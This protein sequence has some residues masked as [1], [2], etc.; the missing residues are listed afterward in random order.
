MLKTMSIL[1]LLATT[2]A[3]AD[4]PTIRLE[5]TRDYSFQVEMATQMV[6]ELTTYEYSGEPLPTV[7]VVTPAEMILL[8]YDTETLIEYEQK[9]EEPPVPNAFYTRDDNTITSI[10]PEPAMHTLVH[11]MVHYFQAL[12]GK[13]D[14][15]AQWPHCLEAEAYDVQA[16]WHDIMQLDMEDRP[17]SGFVMTLYAVCNDADFSWTFN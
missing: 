8:A 2:A 15:F 10:T 6:L 7:K 12:S 5:P 11:E 1:C 3:F 14:E 9:G 13:T 16:T 4:E 17:D